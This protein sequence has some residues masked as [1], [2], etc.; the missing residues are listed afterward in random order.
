MREIIEKLADSLVAVSD[1]SI[2][3][4]QQLPDNLQDD[5]RYFLS[6]CDGGY[7]ADRFFH[8]FG[9]RG[10]HLHNLVEWNRVGF[11]KRY[12][13]LDDK[14][15][16]FAEDIFGTQFCFD[17]RGNR[18]VV[19]MLIP[20]G[21]APSLCA[22]TFVE[23]LEYEVLSDTDNS[24]IRQLARDFYANRGQAF[25]SF[26][27][28]ACKIPP[29]LGGNDSDISNLETIQSSTNLKILGQIALQVK[30]LDPGTRIRDIRI[31]Y[32]KEE[33]TLIVA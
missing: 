17:V 21:R 31:N 33:I 5:Y 25:R 26:T 13:N 11:W 18:R 28:I 4:A 10:P 8:F 1:D 3:P 6:L 32:E 14:T 22:N 7:S 29:S 23:F 30:K 27:H 9:Q 20:D 2:H 15:F 12:F 16:V 24:Q 19:K